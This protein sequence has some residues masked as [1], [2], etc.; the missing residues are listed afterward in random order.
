MGYRTEE[1]CILRLRIDAEGVPT[2][3]EVRRCPPP[4][5]RV[6]VEAARKW[7]F[8][9][10]LEDGRPVSSQFDLNFRFRPSGAA[11]GASGAGHDAT[12]STDP[13]PQ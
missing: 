5:Q 8:Y 7:R 4:F 6:A 13:P 9:P 3:V 10:L 2:A 11:S 12:P 1:S